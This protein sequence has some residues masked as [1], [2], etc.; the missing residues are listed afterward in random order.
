MQPPNS[1]VSLAPAVGTQGQLDLIQFIFYSV[2]G[3]CISQRIERHSADPRQR[4]PAA[5]ESSLRCG[6]PQGPQHQHCV[7]MVGAVQA[8]TPGLALRGAPA[9][10]GWGR[11][12]KGGASP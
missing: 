8:A 9:R 10:D 2:G 5:L 1:S 6:M 11:G 12:G 4:I 7:I 3:R